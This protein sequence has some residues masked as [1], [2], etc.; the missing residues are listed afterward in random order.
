MF[1]Q[2]LPCSSFIFFHVHLV[3]MTVPSL[4]ALHRCQVP[5][6]WAVVPS[7]TMRWSCGN[8]GGQVSLPQRLSE[9]ETGPA[10]SE[11]ATA[12]GFKVSGHRLEI[13]LLL[14]PRYRGK[15]LLSRKQRQEGSLVWPQKPRALAPLG[16]RK[17]VKCSSSFPTWRLPTK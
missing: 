11:G 7:W 16:A 8:G 1:A 5:L 2:R 12:V 15:S 3:R 14:V 9:A 10:A 6:R 4:S 13:E 17:M